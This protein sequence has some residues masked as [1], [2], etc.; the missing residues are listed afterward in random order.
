MRSSAPA[1]QTSSG[2][3]SSAVLPTVNVS[4][5]LTM[6][7]NPPNPPFLGTATALPLSIPAGSSAAS[8]TGSLTNFSTV[9][10]P[11]VGSA[12][13]L[14]S[15]AATSF[16]PLMG[17]AYLY[18]QHSATTMPSAVSAQ[19]QTSMSAASYPAALQWQLTA[20]TAQNPSALGDFTQGTRTNHNTAG[21]C[22]MMT[23]PY[24]QNA[25]ANAPVPLF[26]SFIPGTAAQIPSQGHGLSL[27]YLQAS[28]IHDHHQATEQHFKVSGNKMVAKEE[29]PKRIKSAFQRDSSATIT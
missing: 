25:G 23:A 2:I 28:Q 26:P 29:H 14:S 15:A 19:S 4:S 13:L 20:G 16:Q 1:T 10:A 24:H 21:P 9:S 7:E 22:T 12:W 6:S 27:P 3:A 17:S 11:T 8:L 5:S 18:Q